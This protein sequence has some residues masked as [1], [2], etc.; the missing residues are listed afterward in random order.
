[1][2]PHPHRLARFV[3]F[4]ALIVTAQAA[5]DDTLLL[6]RPTLAQNTI[7]FAYAG[8]VWT[9]GLDGGKARR[10][11]VNAQVD[12]GPF[13]SPDGTQLA[14]SGSVGGVAQL[15]VVAGE[16]GEPRQLTYHAL[17]SAARGWSND[18]KRV[19][20]ASSRLS[21]TV[22]YS[23]LF[24][25][26]ATGGFAEPLPMPMAERGAFSP[27]GARIAYTPIRDAF[28]TWK[29][30]RGGQR[31][32]I[33]L[34]DLKSSAIEKVPVENSND[35][36][37]V[38]LGEVV[39][40]LSDRDGAMNI[41]A[42]DT[43]T[44][45]PTQLTRYSDFDVKSLHGR[46]DTLV[47]EQGGRVH[48]MSVK[49]KRDRTLSIQVAADLA[50]T[51]P[52]FVKAQKYLRGPSISPTGARAVFEA[53]GDIITVPAKKGDARNLT[54]TSG[55]HERAPIWSPDGKRVAWFSDVSGEYQLALGSQNGME[56]VEFHSLGETPSYYHSPAWSPEGGRISY[57][58]KR[59]SYHYFDLATK[60]SVLVDTEP[61]GP[62]RHNFDH[63][64]S[65]D[66]KWLAYARTLQNHL[67][68]V[69]VHEVATG[70]S[71]QITDGMSD[72]ASV[73]WSLDGKYLYFA[74]ST[75]VG[76][77][78]NPLHMQ[79][80][81]RT[82]RRHLY[83]VVLDKK[84]PSPFAPE[85]D[86]EKSPEEKRADDKKSGEAKPAD[87]AGDKA[88]EKD[89]E[90]DDPKP[91]SDKPADA[92]KPA[93]KKPLPKVVVD[94]EGIGQRIIA[95]PVPEGAVD[96]LEAAAD[97]KLF[98]VLNNPGKAAREGTL[99]RFDHKERKSTE[100]L[101]GIRSYEV[102][103]NGEHLLYQSGPEA[104]GIVE[105]KGKPKTGDGALDF[106]NID[107]RVDP[108]AEWAEMWR[109]FWR[110][111]RDYF[112]VANLH[113]ADWRAIRQRYEPWL[114]H[115]GHRADLNY[116][117][118][119]MMGEMVIGHNYVRG[120]D[121]NDESKFNVGL[122]GA[123]V[124]VEG[125]YYKITRIFSGLNWNPE[126]R[127]PLTEPGIN[128]AV[129]DYVLAVNGQAVRTA[130]DFHQPFLNTA[131]KQTVLL[132]NNRPD[133]AGARQVTVVPVASEAGL[134]N[135][136]W[137]EANVEKVRELSGGQ[138]AYVYLPDTA[139]AGFAAFNR[140]Y[141]AQLDRSALVIDERF[142]AGGKVADYIIDALSRPLL[143]YWA[144]REG[145]TYSSPTSAIFGPTVMITN[146]YAGS[147]GDALPAFFRRRNLGPIVGKTTW[148][149]LVGISSYPVLMDGGTVTAPSF[150]IFSPDGK[151]E[152][153]NVGVP[154]DI[155]VE[156]TPAEVIA[157]RDPQLERAVEEVMKLLKAKPF[158]R[159]ARPADPIR[160]R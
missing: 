154:P 95:L 4:L 49:D 36:E 139:E 11:T 85:S 70:K 146:E 89:A 30:Y 102:S 150:G 27:N 25:V 147:G 26:S 3:L 15:F 58:D 44:K 156:M 82:V 117:I 21:S 38:W 67:R 46:G 136:A 72:T 114:A 76:L 129:G 32:N 55:A 111:E 65:P 135:R 125:D 83:L 62:P 57:A 1:M 20:F 118:G 130:D 115:V 73:A 74:A 14:Y 42:Y 35:T 78:I 64:W 132:V 119:E 8:D 87:K 140:Y 109:E 144:T 133:R 127:A 66:G 93:K 75:N 29:R 148:G 77:T 28:A 106:K 13:F 17:S 98:Y 110:I 33:W 104:F 86:E 152:I 159:P 90:A 116:V 54:Q 121:M 138:V 79:A 39:Y 9:T 48:V 37:P 124:A 61:Y 41:L 12:A 7:A 96:D 94:L 92:A 155:E 19:L 84:A 122:L 52:R 24:T 149:G 126:L 81:E 157:G 34:F 105:T 68:A 134:R 59:L 2:P 128:I 153:E 43:R 47:F 22:R 50:A 60:Q 40:F 141:F 103:M 16:G 63:V 10:L 56:P 51:R 100:F 80:Y 131:G 112:Y 108:R 123:D 113:G 45:Q 151:W 145:A 91:D 107:V 101:T 31:S 71:H 120:G 5:S 23:R 137:V 160:G 158:V 18:G 88:T 6:R 142:N 97:G 99:Q 143:S 53:R 69:F